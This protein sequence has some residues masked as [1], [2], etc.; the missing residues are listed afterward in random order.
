MRGKYICSKRERLAKRGK[1]GKRER[2]IVKGMLGTGLVR[3]KSLYWKF[4]DAEEYVLCGTFIKQRF[5]RIY[6]S[7][8]G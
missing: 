8:I 7:D 1:W 6:Y 4:F 3:R 5:L 2:G